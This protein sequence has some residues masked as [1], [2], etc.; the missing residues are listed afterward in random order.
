M[1][2]NPRQEAYRI[3][4]QAIK[5]A[6]TGDAANAEKLYKQAIEINKHQALSNALYAEILSNR[7]R[8]EEAIHHWNNGLVTAP[9]KQI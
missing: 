6:E 3:E 7:D 4:K 9:V 2:W 5:Y 1:F 8:T